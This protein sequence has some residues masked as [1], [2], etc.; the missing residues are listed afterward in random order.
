MNKLLREA[1]RIITLILSLVIFITALPLYVFADEFEIANEKAQEEVNVI[2][3]IEEN[4]AE[5]VEAE[6]ITDSEETL[7]AAEE[8]LETETSEEL[9]TA[10]EE[11]EKAAEELE[12]ENSEE[13]ETAEEEI[14]A[15]EAEVIEEAEEETVEAQ[16][17]EEVQ[18]EIEAEEGLVLMTVTLDCGLK[19]TGMMPKNAVVEAIP[20]S[21]EI[22]GEEVLAAYDINIFENEEM[23]AL[24]IVWQPEEGSISVSLAD[25]SF[26]TE[27]L[28]VYHTPE[29][30]EPELVTTVGA[31]RKSVV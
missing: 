2:K 27:E 4:E 5:R 28:N 15:E 26:G 3:T 9:E 10:E 20:V 24:G 11:A 12:I 19:L 25:D 21:V 16:I 14:E 7:E 1:K 22:D 30:G 13:L 6:E 8:E 18:I 23:K 17:E 31:D 29:G